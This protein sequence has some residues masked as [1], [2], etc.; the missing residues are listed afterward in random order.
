M[1]YEQIS[2]TGRM[3]IVLLERDSVWK[4]FN[5]EK[6]EKYKYFVFLFVFFWVGVGGGG[7]GVRLRSKLRIPLNHDLWFKLRIIP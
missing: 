5:L 3:K 1:T 4:S 6:L 2:F 7:G